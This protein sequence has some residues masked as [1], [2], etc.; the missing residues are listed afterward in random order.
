MSTHVPCIER[1]LSYLVLDNDYAGPLE[2]VFH[3]Q[4]ELRTE[5]DTEIHQAEGKHQWIEDGKEH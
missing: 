4:E 5:L 1:N 2:Q 3:R